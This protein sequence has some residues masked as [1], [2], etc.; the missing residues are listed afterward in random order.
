MSMT[1]GLSWSRCSV[2]EDQS[3]S[4]SHALSTVGRP[5][6]DDVGC[7][8]EGVVG[9]GIAYGC[10]VDRLSESLEEVRVDGVPGLYGLYIAVL[11][12]G[13]NVIVIVAKDGVC[14]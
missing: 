5:P 9:Y 10:G 13:V 7:V 3:R 6:V 8:Y 4:L 12:L 2:N 14:P 1:H 11:V